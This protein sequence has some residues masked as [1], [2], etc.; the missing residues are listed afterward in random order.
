MIIKQQKEQQKGM[1][2][3]KIKTLSKGSNSGNVG[4]S[5]GF[6]NILT[7]T[8]IIGFI[9]GTIFMLIYNILK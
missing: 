6:A 1:E 3:P 2:K 9:A 4:S 7:L 5:S 8:L